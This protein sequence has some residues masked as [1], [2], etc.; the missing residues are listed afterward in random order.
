MKCP[1]CGNEF[2]YISAMSEIDERYGDGIYDRYYDSPE[3]WCCVNCA[4]AT[5][6]AD[7]G[8]GAELINIM[9]GDDY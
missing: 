4:L 9:C 5:I 8:T 3:T 6:S 7:Y 2:E 1:E